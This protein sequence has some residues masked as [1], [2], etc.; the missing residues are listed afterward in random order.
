MGHS[1][2]QLLMEIVG[3]PSIKPINLTNSTE[4]SLVRLIPLAI[5]NKVP[6]LFLEKA[7]ELSAGSEYLQNRYQVYM[8]RARTARSFMKQVAQVLD[9][10]QSDYAIFKTIKPFQSFGADVDVILFNRHD[11][12]RVYCSFR[13]RGFGIVGHGPF[14]ATLYAPFY[15]MGVDL[16]VQIAVSHLVYLDIQILKESVTETN[17]EG[18]KVRILNRPASFVAD[19]THSIYKEQ[20]LTLA[21]LYTAFFEL[22]SMNG[23]Q[24]EAMAQLANRV[25]AALSVKAVLVVANRLLT[26]AFNDA[27]P[28]A[29]E[30][31]ELIHVT[32]IEESIIRFLTTNLNQNFE[33]PYKYPLWAVAAAFAYKIRSDPT[34]RGSVA[35]Q[36][37]E[38]ILNM[39]YLFENIRLHMKGETN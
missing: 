10:T 27:I 9:Q 35:R 29:T 28:G 12:E 1:D 15:G 21:D 17:V 11:L 26:L 6:V 36:T 33:L 34:M 20:S 25:H 22:L 37:A 39:P 31:V 30:A 8:E 19:A 18:M 4:T 24:L 38:I 7:L 16:H 3:M 14:S 2:T 5:K 13:N 32:K 23:P